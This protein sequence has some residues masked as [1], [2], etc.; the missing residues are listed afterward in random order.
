STCRA[1]SRSRDGGTA[2][3]LVRAW[4]SSVVMASRW[5]TDGT[6]PDSGSLPGAM[7]RR[8]GSCA[9]LLRIPASA[10][11]LPCVPLLPLVP[12]RRRLLRLLLDAEL[13]AYRV[14]E[15]PA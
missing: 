15:S 13:P 4:V 2:L 10:S 5:V 11:P 3:P 14:D 8:G 6:F 7:C 9:T 1:A 12:L